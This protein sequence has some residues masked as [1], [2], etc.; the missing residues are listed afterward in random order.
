MQPSAAPPMLPSPPMATT[1]KASTRTETPM[2]GSTDIIGAV[3]APPSA[4]RNVPSAK[5]MRSMRGT[6]MPSAPRHLTVVDDAGD[7][8]A[9]RGV[10]NDEPEQEACN[11]RNSRQQ[12]RI[13]GKCDAAHAHTAEQA[14]RTLDQ[15][16]FDPPDQPNHVLQDKEQRKGRQQTDDLV[17]AINATKEHAL[18]ERA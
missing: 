8:A 4:A 16:R 13:A 1:A 18:D 9:E 14:E 7:L 6:L 5:A 17:L 15:I 11:G 3:N 2:P 12:E 10:V